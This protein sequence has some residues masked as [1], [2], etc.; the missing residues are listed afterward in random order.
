MPQLMKQPMMRKVI[1][2]LVPIFAHSVWLYGLRTLIVTAISCAVGI[3]VEWAFERKRNGKVSEAVFVTGILFAFAMP[4]AIPLWIVAVGSAF[5]VFMAKEVY[6]G[7]GRNVFNPA[8]SGRLF[9]YLSFAPVLGRSFIPSGSFG[10]S[11][12]AFWTGSMIGTPDAISGATPLAL[13][14]SG[15]T[16]DPIVLLLG[17]RDGSVGEG[18]FALI[19][20][21]GIYLVATKTANWRIIVSSAVSA[22]IATV[23]FL[24]MGLKGA[25]PVESLM[26]GSLAFVIVF[27][28]T[29][30]VSAPKKK[31]SLWMYGAMIG[32]ITI[33]IRT[34]SAFPEGTSFAVLLG[35]T[36]AP[37]LDRQMAKLGAAGRKNTAIPAESG[38]PGA[39]P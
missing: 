36:F 29:D 1:I 28:A 7:F 20:L 9:V 3:A 25:L 14:R 32:I 21:A 2:A 8:I 27:M 22:S 10:A 15:L 35:N 5:A 4:P 33:V 19:V 26:A 31:G 6:G 17:F 16:V 23:A 38:A 24:A 30:P 37:F 34:F 39:K 11:G 18:S 12:G 13:M